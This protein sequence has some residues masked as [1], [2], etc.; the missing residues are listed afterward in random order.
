MS[1]W[2]WKMN[3]NIEKDKNGSL[4]HTMY[5]IKHLNGLGN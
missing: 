1:D 2:S 3:I 5:K 4:S